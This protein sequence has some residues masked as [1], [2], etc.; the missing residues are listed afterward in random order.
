M[1]K[2]SV[3]NESPLPK[4]FEVKAGLPNVNIIVLH[5]NIITQIYM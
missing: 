2:Y 5:H 1:H 3:T 4:L